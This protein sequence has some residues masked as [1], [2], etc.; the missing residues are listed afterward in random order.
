MIGALGK[1]IPT[2]NVQSDPPANIVSSIYAYDPG[3]GYTIATTL[4]PGRG[5][6]VKMGAAGTLTL[7]ADATTPYKMPAA[8]VD[9]AA[10][11]AVVI[12]DALGRSQTLYFGDVA[13]N[14]D[15]SAFELPPPPPQG[16]FD[17]RFSTQ[18]IVAGI[19]TGRNAADITLGS[20][21][22]PVTVTFVQGRSGAAYSVA[23]LNG[24][25]NESVAA[26]HNGAAVT[27]TEAAGGKLS[28]RLTGGSSL[29]SVFALGRSYPNPF[30]PVTHFT[31]D[32]PAA[33]AV[34]VAVYNVIGQKVATI[35]S[36]VRGAGSSEM[37]WNGLSDNGV[38]APSGIYF[39]RMTAPEAGFSAM[40]KVS[41]L[42]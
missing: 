2:S 25:G 39:I 19:G 23:S 33:S 41:F 3:A 6:W 18:R 17:A 10:M 34:E 42:K 8:T 35:F 31:V 22:Y 1:S 37:T 26:L 13:D 11:D 30:N 14:A 7:S 36:G 40:Q 27:L 15:L 9:I 32:V 12:T 24:R 4:E 5:H 38:A 20:A 16:N 29:P 28:L 21:V